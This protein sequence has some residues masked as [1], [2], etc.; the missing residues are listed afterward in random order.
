VLALGETVKAFIVLKEGETAT[1]LRKRGLTVAN[2]R[3]HIQYQEPAL[4]GDELNIVTYLSGI[5]GTGCG[6]LP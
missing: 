2:R 1:R 6:M 3:V 4:W 5:G